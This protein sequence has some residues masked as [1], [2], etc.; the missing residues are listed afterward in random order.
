MRRSL[1]MAEAEASRLLWRYTT[2]ERRKAVEVR[3]LDNGAARGPYDADRAEAGAPL[4]ERARAE[5]ATSA[6]LLVAY[7]GSGDNANASS[8]A[9]ALAVQLERPPSKRK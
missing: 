3:T 8:L 2:P 6:E 1:E 7:T 5:F 9:R 4:L